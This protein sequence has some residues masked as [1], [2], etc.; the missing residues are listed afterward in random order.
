MG[1]PWG[2]GGLFWEDLEGENGKKIGGKIS[3][4]Q[5]RVKIEKKKKNSTGNGL[6]SIGNS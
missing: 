5:N 4:W 3:N 2:I 1:D 6:R